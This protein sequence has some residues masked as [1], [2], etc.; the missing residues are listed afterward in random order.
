ML[1]GERLIAMKRVLGDRPQEQHNKLHSGQQ[2]AAV[3]A[4]IHTQADV[5]ENNY[6]EILVACKEN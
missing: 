3:Y 5:Y 1:Y 4:D 2:D 6:F